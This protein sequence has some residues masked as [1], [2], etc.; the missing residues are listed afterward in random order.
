MNQKFLE[1]SINIQADIIRLERH[2]FD[3]YPK[4]AERAADQ[5][6]VLRVAAGIYNELA[7]EDAKWIRPTKRLL[8]ST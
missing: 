1:Q 5:I 2:I 4:R 6:A 8:P 3:M 7:V